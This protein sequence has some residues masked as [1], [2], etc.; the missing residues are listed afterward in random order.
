MYATTNGRCAAI[1][2]VGASA[3]NIVAI[4]NGPFPADDSA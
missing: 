2:P 3:I 1:S 4:L